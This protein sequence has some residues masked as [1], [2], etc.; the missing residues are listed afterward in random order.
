MQNER[1]HL[2]ADASGTLSEKRES[3]SPPVRKIHKGCKVSKG[4]IK[5]GSASGRKKQG[6][7]CG[8]KDCFKKTG[9]L[10]NCTTNEVE[11]KRGRNRSEY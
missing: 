8:K 4:A 3:K 5:K 2:Y 6:V 11:G 10:G 7:L 1:L 9:H